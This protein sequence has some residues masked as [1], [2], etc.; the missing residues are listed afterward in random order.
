MLFNEALKMRPELRPDPKMV[1]R[2]EKLIDLP[3]VEKAKGE[4][5]DPERVR[6]VVEQA[7]AV[8]VSSMLKSICMSEIEEEN[9]R[10]TQFVKGFK[11]KRN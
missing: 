8:Y 2:I 1:N 11:V 5:L 10:F 9:P 6:N 4:L 3:R 7:E